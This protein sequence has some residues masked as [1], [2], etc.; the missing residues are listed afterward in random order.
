MQTSC[1]F[2]FLRLSGI[3]KKRHLQWT[4][5]STYASLILGNVEGLKEYSGEGI[6]ECCKNLDGNGEANANYTV[7]ISRGKNMLP[8]VQDVHYWKHKL[9]PFLLVIARFLLKKYSMLSS[10]C[11]FLCYEYFRTRK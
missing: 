7:K 11:N 4:D 5:I 8:Y 3:E 2:L 10:F 6:R 1:C 9:A